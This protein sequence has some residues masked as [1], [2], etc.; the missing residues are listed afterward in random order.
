MKCD[1]RLV[2]PCVKRGQRNYYVKDPATGRNVFKK[3]LDIVSIPYVVL[4]DGIQLADRYAEHAVSTIHT[5]DEKLATKI[6]AEYLIRTNLKF[7]F[8]EGDTLDIEKVR[9]AIFKVPQECVDLGWHQR[10]RNAIEARVA[11]YSPVRS[12]TDIVQGTKR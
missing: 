6:V 12:L 5:M 10:M 2:V 7:N 1:E 4:E 11:V 8:D 3:R 9:P